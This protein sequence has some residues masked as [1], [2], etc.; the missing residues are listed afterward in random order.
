[1]AI[2]AANHSGAGEEAAMTVEV[3][4]PEDIKDKGNRKLA[5]LIAILALF[6]ALAEIGGKQAEGDSVAANIEASNLW[7]F[8]QA[9][10]IRAT[11]LRTAAEA[12]ETTSPAIADPELRKAAAVRVDGWR[13]TAAR[14]DSEPETQEGRQELM[15]RAKKAEG[16]RDTAAA[17]HHHCEIAS[18]LFQIAIVLAS[19]VIITGIA[20][21]GWGAIALGVLGIGFTGIG[22]FAPQAMHLF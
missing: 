9:K 19:A 18:A 6:L 4:I 16:K 3:E 1:M 22:L 12:M 15:A 5:L 8:F 21:L 17:A 13:K 11:T 7:A 2:S 10:T 14:Y 20:A